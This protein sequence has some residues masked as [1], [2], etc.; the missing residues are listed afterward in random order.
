MEIKKLYASILNKNPILLTRTKLIFP[1]YSTHSEA[2]EK[3]KEA[4]YNQNCWYIK[5][6]N[7]IVLFSIKWKNQRLEVENLLYKGSEKVT[8]LFILQIIEKFARSYFVS[9]ITFSFFTKGVLFPWL[10][11]QGYQQDEH[12]F[13]K[14]LSYHTALVLSGGGARGAYQIGAWRALKELGISFE[15]ITSTSVGTLNAALI[16]MNDETKAQ[17]LW[18]KISTEQIL[19]FPQAAA[20]N[21]SFKQLT[22]QLRSL[23]KTAMKEKGVSTLPLQKLMV[24][25]LDE[26]KLKTS[27]IK[28]YICT[29]RLKGLKEKVVAIHSIKQSWKWLTAS[30]A[31]FPAMQPVRIQGEDYVD[32]GYRND[33]PLDVALSKG[34]K[35][36]ICI[37]A[38]GPGVRKKIS[39]PENVVNVQLRSPWPLGSFL[40]FD[41]KR[42]K[43]NE[44]LGYLEMLK[45]FGKYTGFWYT[46][47]NMTDW[48]TNWQAFIMSLSAQEFALLKKSNFWQ[49]F[50]KYHG[51]KVSLEQVG[52]AF[53]ELI[54]R[55]LRLPADRSYTKEQF[56]NA[57]MKKKTE[58]SFPPELVRS[59]NEWVELYYKDYFFLSKKNQFLFLDALLEKDMHLSKWFIEQTEVLFIAAKFFHF[60]KNET[61][62]KC[63]I[64]NEE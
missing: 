23:S 51:K 16:M 44:R 60:L 59:F 21:Y 10:T 12:G 32:G 3:M 55:I 8:W 2:K 53:V 5:T 31:F 61:E 20:T 29:T 35:E 18:Y 33:F 9:K 47:S 24:Q 49:K 58:L 4:V 19:A 45:Y 38:K 36:C 17:Q 14:E 27:S 37:D 54:G 48:Q 34:A 15:M 22:R 6:G 42:S 28:F 63:V 57:F 64:N 30:A 39:L 13:S 52:E 7:W 25:T 41:S 40:I 11:S 50:Y 46:F 43:V 26:A 62:E 1:F 56:L